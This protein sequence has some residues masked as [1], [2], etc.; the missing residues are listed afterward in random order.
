MISSDRLVW[1][2]NS[3]LP[4]SEA[5]ISALSPSSQFG[6]SVFEG[7]RG[8]W[9]EENN[10]LYLFRLKDH[11]N[12]AFFSC[13]LVGLD[14]NYSSSELVE[15][16]TKTVKVNG[17][18]S[19]IALRLIFCLDHEGSWSATGS[20]D[21]LIAPVLKDRHC[22]TSPPCVSAAFSS[23]NRITDQCLPPRVKLGANYANSR[24]AHLD[25]QNKGF[26][27]PFFLDDSGFVSE[28][29]GSCI[30]YLKDGILH[31]PPLECSVLE[32]IT[33][34]TILSLAQSLDIPT[35]VT[36]F[37]RTN[38]YDADEVFICG[39]AAEITPVTRVDRFKIGNT[40]Q[41]GFI[42][43][44]LLNAYHELVSNKLILDPSWLTLCY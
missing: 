43:L 37:H 30:F 10:Q 23:W 4:A 42:S 8:Y 6:I 34:D 41:G 13:K 40:S 39:S 27:I 32:S 15:L 33:R 22:S 1:F 25:I 16:V 38:I 35:N 5:R 9:S 3:F 29:S 20:S 2:K 18:K 12:R 17:Y 7:I 21:L 31:T 36:R 26:D 28:S 14:I 19:D 24:Y 44:K 11:I